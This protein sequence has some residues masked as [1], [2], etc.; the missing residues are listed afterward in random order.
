VWGRAT[1]MSDP[2]APVR[3]IVLALILSMAAWAVI[4]G[5]LGV[6]R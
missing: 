2:M 5:V 4:L 1:D 6:L 3:G